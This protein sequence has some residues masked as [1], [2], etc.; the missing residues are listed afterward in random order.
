MSV[1]GVFLSHPAASHQGRGSSMGSQWGQPMGFSGHCPASP[2]DPRLISTHNKTLPMGLAMRCASEQRLWERRCCCA[3]DPL[4]PGGGS[5]CPNNMHV[6]MI[7]AIMGTRSC[8]AWRTC[9]GTA[10]Q[11]EAPAFAW[12][13]AAA[14]ILCASGCRWPWAR[15]SSAC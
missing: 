5:S 8:S 14:L 3:K 4:A 10:G 1:L 6:D 11:G 12:L 13:P 15:R 2:R 7:L 9:C